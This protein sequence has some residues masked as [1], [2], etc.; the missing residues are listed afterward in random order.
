M[1]TNTTI[2]ED[3]FTFTSVVNATTTLSHLLPMKVLPE[4]K[5]M[6]Q[7]RVDFD[8]LFTYCCDVNTIHNADQFSM[9]FD[10]VQTV[11]DTLYSTIKRHKTFTV[12]IIDANHKCWHIYDI[13]AS[14]VRITDKYDYGCQVCVITGKHANYICTE[15][16]N[17]YMD[18][19]DIDLIADCL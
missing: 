13:R 7:R 16:N 14:D 9:L 17:K 10:A 18:F 3:V 19:T 4:L 12:A 11:Q 8:E 6:V 5:A 2:T 1:K 15:G